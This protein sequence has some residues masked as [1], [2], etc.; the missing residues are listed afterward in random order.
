[1]MEPVY[2]LHFDTQPSLKHY[3]NTHTH[4]LK[5]T[6]SNKW[7]C[8]QTWAIKHWSDIWMSELHTH[9]LQ[10]ARPSHTTAHHINTPVHKHTCVSVCV[11]DHYGTHGK[12]VCF[13]KSHNRL[14]YV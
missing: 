9:Q 2:P 7:V 5:Q 8:V 14:I 10:S 3:P 4:T 11:W 12:Y 6:H 13:K 1:M